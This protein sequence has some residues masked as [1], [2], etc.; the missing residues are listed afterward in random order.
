MLECPLYNVDPATTTTIIRF[1]QLGLSWPQVTKYWVT[2]YLMFTC[3]ILL[4]KMGGSEDG[5]ATHQCHRGSMFSLPTCSAFL[6]RCGL[7]VTRQLPW[8]QASYLHPRIL[9]AGRKE[10]AKGPFLTCF[11]IRGGQ[12]SQ[13]FPMEFSS[14][15]AG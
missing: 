6:S 3:I 14:L 1:Y 10:R 7:M 12:F 9:S 4:N 5:A 8:F 11:F 13:R 15:R 2:I